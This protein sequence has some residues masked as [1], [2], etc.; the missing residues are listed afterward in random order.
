[1]GGS[2][3]QRVRNGLVVA[4]VALALTLL[5]GAGLMVRSFMALQNAD[6]GID[7]KNTLTFRVGLPP[8][9]ISRTN[10]SPAAFS[11]S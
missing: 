6:I 11:S 8:V 2:K 10:K 9:A 7:P 3:G 5:I 1:M 4:E